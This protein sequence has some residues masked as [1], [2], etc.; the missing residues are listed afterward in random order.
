MNHFLRKKNNG[1]FSSQFSKCFQKAEDT[2]EHQ[3]MCRGLCYALVRIGP[4][5][6]NGGQAFEKHLLTGR[7]F[8]VLSDH[9]VKGED[10]FL[11]FPTSYIGQECI[12]LMDNETYKSLKTQ[13]FKMLVRVF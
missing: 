10:S 5:L 7:G 13:F 3:A 11:F 4:F 9:V 6:L 12:T 1:S 2:W 8:F